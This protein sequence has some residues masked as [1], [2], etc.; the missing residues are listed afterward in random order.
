M[1]CV[2]GAR[3]LRLPYGASDALGVWRLF[4]CRRSRIAAC[5][6]YMPTLSRLLDCCI[7]VR[8]LDSTMTLFGE[9]QFNIIF[10]F[11]FDRKAN[12]P[13]VVILRIESRRLWPDRNDTTPRNSIPRGDYLT[14]ERSRLWLSRGITSINYVGAFERLMSRH[15][16]RRVPTLF[17][18]F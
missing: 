18:D 10:D 12:T 6:P 16:A 14:A 7:G 15:C 5:M 4:S 17:N 3:T 8:N 1:F 9:F 2:S 11:D 13:V